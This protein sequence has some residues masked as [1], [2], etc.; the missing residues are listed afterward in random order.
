MDAFEVFENYPPGCKGDN[1]DLWA[2]AQFDT[3]G[4]QFDMDSAQFD[5]EGDTYRDVSDSN[6]TKSGLDEQLEG[7]TQQCLFGDF[8]FL[9]PVNDSGLSMSA[10]INQRFLDVQ[11]S[12]VSKVLDRKS[13]DSTEC[14]QGVNALQPPTT[15]TQES[16]ADG[17]PPVCVICLEPAGGADGALL[18][19]GCGCN[20]LAHKGCLAELARHKSTDPEC[21]LPLK[22]IYSQCHAC[23]RKVSGQAMLELGMQCYKDHKARQF[24]TPAKRQA[25]IV[26]CRAL[27]E[28]GLHSKALPHLRKLTQRY[29]QSKDLCG[30][31]EH[32]RALRRL[33]LAQFHVGRLDEAEVT[34]RKAF[35]FVKGRNNWHIC[36]KGAIVEACLGLCLSR[37]GKLGEGSRHTRSAMDRLTSKKMDKLRARFS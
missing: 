16:S 2:G 21:M 27:Q 17:T 32:L 34:L 15:K 23:K 10:I 31:N 18:T 5:T 8:Q 1:F 11:E 9:Q 19:G 28:H 36:P 7:D 33:A 12:F 4:A 25:V 26:Y 29:Q 20:L 37:A 35:V 22:Q 30:Y 3:E 24:G 6:L 13:L 14:A